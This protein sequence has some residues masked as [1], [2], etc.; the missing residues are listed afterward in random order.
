MMS[1]TFQ[2]GSRLQ[3]KLPTVISYNSPR[4]RAQFSPFFP[5]ILGHCA[6]LL[7]SAPDKG[8]VGGSSPPRPTI[9]ISKY[10]AILTF[11]LFGDLPQRPFCQPF[12]N[13]TFSRIPLHSRRSEAT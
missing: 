5:R 12:V 11:S 13:F 6:I 7:V 2:L 1:R 9:Q 3:S 8:E 4:G 10:A